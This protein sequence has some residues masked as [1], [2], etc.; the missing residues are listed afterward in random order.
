MQKSQSVPCCMLY[1]PQLSSYF[2]KW[3][4]QF[5]SGLQS[6]IWMNHKTSG[7]VS[8]GQVIPKERFSIKT[9][10][11][12]SVQIYQKNCKTQWW[13]R[14]KSGL[15]CRDRTKA[16]CSCWVDRD[17][18][19]M[20]KCSR[21]KCGETESPTAQRPETRQQICRERLTKETIKMF[22]MYQS[23]FRPKSDWNATNFKQ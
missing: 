19:N 1:R 13:W 18:I 20:S 2:L 14:D 15:F 3:T 17:L 23:K 11:M 10:V 4:E 5:K 6:C 12:L 16:P 21:V 8:T 22:E 7:P 9:N